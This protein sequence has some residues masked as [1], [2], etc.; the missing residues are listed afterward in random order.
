MEQ[1]ENKCCLPEEFL[2]NEKSEDEN[3]LESDEEQDKP[4]ARQPLSKEENYSLKNILVPKYSF[5]ELTQP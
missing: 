2:Q 1:E 5:N 4:P 3:E